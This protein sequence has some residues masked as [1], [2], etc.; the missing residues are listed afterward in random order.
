MYIS[1]QSVQRISLPRCLLLSETDV[2][3]HGFCDAS[4]EAYGAFIYV[5]SRGTS[6]SSHLLCSK[7]RVAPLKTLAVPK[8]ELCGAVL[9][10]KLMNEVIKM[11]ILNSSFLLLV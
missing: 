8:L 5:L 6:T 4:E 9:L 1:F 3:I 2:K 11:G 10:A 7:S